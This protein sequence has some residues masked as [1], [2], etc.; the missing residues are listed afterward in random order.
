MNDTAP[1]MPSGAEDPANKLTSPQFDEFKEALEILY[2]IGNQ[3]GRIQFTKKW[4][5]AAEHVLGAELLLH[6]NEGSPDKERRAE[7]ESDADMRRIALLEFMDNLEENSVDKGAVQIEYVKEHVERMGRDLSLLIYGS[8]LVD[9]F[10][11]PPPPP[12]PEEGA[13]DQNDDAEAEA[14]EHTLPEQLDVGAQA[15]VP[16]A[17]KDTKE[18]PEFEVSPEME[19]ALQKQAQQRDHIQGAAQKEIKDE[20]EAG[21]KAAEQGLIQE[22]GSDAQSLIPEN[23][24]ESAPADPMD[25]IKPIDM[26]GPASPPSEPATP[27]PRP[28]EPPQST[29]EAIMQPQPPEGTA[30]HQDDPP[31][32]QQPAPSP[33]QPVAPD[34]P[35]ESTNNSAPP[36]QQPVPQTPESTAPDQPKTGQKPVAM[37][38]VSS[39]DKPKPEGEGDS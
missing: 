34:V 3:S 11:A 6:D 14:A 18:S 30:S 8:K 32:R 26:S 16:E 38:F 31:V 12:P 4:P 7:L 17:L 39:K 24:A 2:V 23:P 28:D 35:Q 25:Q 10:I 37:K 15:D 27:V 19:A 1:P 20:V 5:V 22:D 29:P 21:K 33:I 36:I 9:R 13:D